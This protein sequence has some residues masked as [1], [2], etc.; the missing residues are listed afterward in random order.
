MT[1][2]IF[3]IQ[4][5]SI[6]D[7]PGIR[8]TV[9]LKGCPLR[10]KWCHNPESFKMQ[11]ETYEKTYGRIET[12]EN[13]INI[14]KRDS[15]Y[16]EESGGGVTFSGGEPTL[17]YDFLMSLLKSSK[18]N[19]LHTCIE[20]SGYMPSSHLLS[21][22]EYVDLF[23]YDYKLTDPILHKKYTGVDNRLILENLDI[24]NKYEQTVI[25]RCPIIPGIND[26]TEHFSAIKQLGKKYINI[27]KTEI[28]P[29]HNIGVAKWKELGLQYDFPNMPSVDPKTIEKWKGEIL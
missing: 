16:Y 25:L 23:L 11:I 27:T 22:I 17:Q 24:L 6:H 4:R 1:G 9:F 2:I 18:E 8:T 13:I 26:N 20:T 7:G 21:L 15:I 12:T 14:V 5:F 10:C 29:Y 3:S 19:G 28:M